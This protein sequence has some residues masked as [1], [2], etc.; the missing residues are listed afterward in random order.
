MF[1]DIMSI[2]VADSYRFKPSR[3]SDKILG[4]FIEEVQKQITEGDHSLYSQKDGIYCSVTIKHCK[5]INDTLLA[6][7]QLQ[8][9]LAETYG[10][11]SVV[12]VAEGH[13]QFPTHMT[14]VVSFKV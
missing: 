12:Y 11:A 4:D 14:V 7:T 10:F 1:K 8:D 13:M 9:K 2:K 3:G 5:Y 6:I